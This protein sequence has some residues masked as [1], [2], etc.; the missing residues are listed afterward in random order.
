MK[1]CAERLFE[2]ERMEEVREENGVEK[3]ESGQKMAVISN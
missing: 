3:G 2:K 1:C